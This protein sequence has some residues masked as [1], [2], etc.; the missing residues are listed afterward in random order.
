MGTADTQTDGARIAPGDVIVLKR[1]LVV[2]DERGPGPR[3]ETS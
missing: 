1:T 2:D 3:R